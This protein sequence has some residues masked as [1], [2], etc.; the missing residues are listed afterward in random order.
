MSRNILPEEKDSV[1]LL[2]IAQDFR[3]E[4]L[5]RRSILTVPNFPSNRHARDRD[6]RR[7]INVPA[8]EAHA[9]CLPDTTECGGGA[10]SRARP[11]G[12]YTHQVARMHDVLGEFHAAF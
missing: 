11:A 8:Y 5:A 2:H 3:R 7:R 9:A 12:C 10:R 6:L 4:E 1:T